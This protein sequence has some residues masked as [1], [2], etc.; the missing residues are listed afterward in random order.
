MRAVMVKHTTE[1]KGYWFEAPNN[2][3]DKI[4]PGVRVVCDTAIGQQDGTVS[5]VQWRGRREGNHDRCRR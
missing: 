2:L 1:S 4:H 5:S 3:A